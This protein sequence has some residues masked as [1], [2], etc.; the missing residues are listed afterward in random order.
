MRR[1]ES[2]CGL[3]FLAAL[4]G[5]CSH[6][7]PL[8]KGQAAI[9]LSSRSVALLSVTVS[10]QNRPD[11]QPF[12]YIVYLEGSDP[13]AFV[14]DEEAPHRSK[15]GHSNEYLLNFD[16]KPGSLK[17]DKI[18][19]DY[20]GTFIGARASIPMNLAMNIKPRAANYLGHIHVL[21]RAKR[22]DDEDSAG[23]TLP[24]INQATAG[25]SNG[26]YEVTVEDRYDEDMKWFMAEYPALRT[27]LVEKSLLPAWQRPARSAK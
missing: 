27:V 23:P 8:S 19:F 2:W 3:V 7:A 24:L 15:P 6:H 25:F 10:N 17:L 9:D 22:S 12:P 5:A 4:L 14:L 16:A 18:W 13:D 1:L 26:T 20:H 11:Y 21:I